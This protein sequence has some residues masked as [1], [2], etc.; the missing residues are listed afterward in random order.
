MKG[1]TA[2]FMKQ[3]RDSEATKNR[4]LMAA[5]A[6]FAD[7][8]L[9]GAR[10]DSIAEKAQTNK[11]MIYQYFGNKEQLYVNILEITYGRLTAEEL[12]IEWEIMPA[13]ISIQKIIRLYFEFLEK[14]P[15]YVKLILCENLNKGKYIEQIDFTNTKSSV[16]HTFTDIMDRG[17]K[18]GEFKKEIDTQQVILSLLTFTFSYFSNRY[19]LS[20]LLEFNLFDSMNTQKRIKIVTDMLLKYICCE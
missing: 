5:E 1:I 6:E 14:N 7:K 11:R 16:F 12:Q 20:K 15:S 13:K 3:K 10:I 9:Y 2:I 8:G 19:T 4:I 17:K 18:T